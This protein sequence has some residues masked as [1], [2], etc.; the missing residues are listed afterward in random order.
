M[1]CSVLRPIVCR[2]PTAVLHKPESM[3]TLHPGRL[4]PPASFFGTHGSDVSACCWFGSSASVRKGMRSMSAFPQYRP[5][6]FCGFLQ[7]HLAQLLYDCPCLFT[8]SLQ[9]FLCVNRLEHA[10]EVFHPSTRG[11]C[12]HIPVEMYN[13]ALILCFRKYFT[14]DFQH[15]QALISN[16]QPDAIQSSAFQPFEEALPAG[17]VLLPAFLRAQNFTVPVFCDTDCHQNRNVLIFTAPVPFQVDAVPIPLWI[18]PRKRPLSPVLDVYIRLLVQFADRGRRYLAAPQRF[19]D[20]F[21]TA[22]RY[23][24]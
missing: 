3:P 2:R 12:E 8:R 21:Y 18:P 13:A 23:T 20:V 15:T 19:R 4:Q 6:P 11:S 14:H 9:C 1:S 5:P 16:N 22:Y 10:R 17:F 7:P 24:R